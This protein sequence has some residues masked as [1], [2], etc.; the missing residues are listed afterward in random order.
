MGWNPSALWSLVARRNIYTVLITGQSAF[1]VLPI[2][3][4]VYIPHNQ[5]L[6]KVM[7]HLGELKHRKLTCASEAPKMH[8]RGKIPEANPSPLSWF[9]CEMAPKGS[10]VGK[11]GFPAGGPILK[12]LET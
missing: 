4:L 12:G 7:L 11:L 9:E 8:Y 10:W 1:Q 6:G 5:S 2:Y 3:H